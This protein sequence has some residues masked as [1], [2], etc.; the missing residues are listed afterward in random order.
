MCYNGD[1]MD[2]QEPRACPVHPAG[3]PPWRYTCR[4]C[5]AIFVMPAPKGP[6][7][8]KGRTCPSCTSHDIV[9]R[10]TV[11]SKACPPGG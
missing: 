11:S 4:N 10:A 3:P 6:S 7:E 8:E 1:G 9:W 5:G 2:K